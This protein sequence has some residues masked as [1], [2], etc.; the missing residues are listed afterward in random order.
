MKEFLKSVVVISKCARSFIIGEMP[1][2]DVDYFFH[3][4]IDEL[5]RESLRHWNFNEAEVKGVH[6]WLEGINAKGS[7]EINYVDVLASSSH[8]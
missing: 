2:T 8:V 1:E 4:K 3:V 5:L 7:C 6:V